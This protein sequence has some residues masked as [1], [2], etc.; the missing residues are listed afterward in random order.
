MQE[1]IKIQKNKNKKILIIEGDFINS[2]MLKQYLEDDFNMLYARDAHEVIKI[3]NEH[4]V[5]LVLLNTDYD[6]FGLSAKDLLK[7]IKN[8]DVNNKIKIIALPNHENASNAL[9]HEF[10][11]SIPHPY[12]KDEVIEN[13]GKLLKVR[14]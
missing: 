5:D 4:F 12:T 9:D 6:S 14:D 11:A 3:M 8:K 1:T 13:I 7:Y 2:F 10:D